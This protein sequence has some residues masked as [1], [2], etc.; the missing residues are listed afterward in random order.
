[1]TGGTEDAG[2]ADFRGLLGAQVCDVLSLNVGHSGGFIPF[3]TLD[4]AVFWS[5]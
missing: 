4:S 2:P 5:E 1:M 3:E